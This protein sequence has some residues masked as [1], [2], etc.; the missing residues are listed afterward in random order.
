MGGLKEISVE[1]IG[2]Y[3]RKLASNQDY[4]QKP[5]KSCPFSATLTEGIQFKGI[6]YAAGTYVCSNNPKNSSDI[7][8]KIGETPLTPNRRGESGLV[9]YGQCTKG[10]YQ[11]ELIVVP[12]GRRVKP[13]PAV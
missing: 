3:L 4:P 8:C 7:L 12:I 13:S 11:T 6:D 2:I 1:E 9:I 10:E 5:F